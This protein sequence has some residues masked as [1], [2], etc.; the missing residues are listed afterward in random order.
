M[1]WLGVCKG[2]FEKTDVFRRLT[3]QVGKVVLSQSGSIA[4]LRNVPLASRIHLSSQTGPFTFLIY[5][6]ILVS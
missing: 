5:I 1:R 4:G 6:Y 3:G 2:R